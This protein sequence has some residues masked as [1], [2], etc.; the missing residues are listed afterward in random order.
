MDAKVGVSDEYKASGLSDSKEGP[1]WHLL[2]WER[3]GW[4]RVEG[5]EWD[6]EFGHLL[7]MPSRPGRQEDRSVESPS[8]REKR[9]S[10][11]RIGF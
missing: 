11:L 8:R 9:D 6:Q 5:T 7:K 2:S 4:N 1:C 3:R 10:S